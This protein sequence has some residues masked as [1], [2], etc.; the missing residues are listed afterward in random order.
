HTH[1][2]AA[3][4]DS[5]G[6]I[7]SI[8]MCPHS[9]EDSCD[10]RK[11]RPGLLYRAA[12]QLGLDLQRSVL[13]GDSA[14]DVFAALAAGCHPIFVGSADA[15][16]AGLPDGLLSRAA[17]LSE[18]V[19]LIGARSEFGLVGAGSNAAAVNGV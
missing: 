5:G 2:Q 8:C 13:I 19:E 15:A 17:S 6:P 1:M 16:V 7:P 12:T 18:A 14:A 4:A 11:P 10:C 9:P 3:M